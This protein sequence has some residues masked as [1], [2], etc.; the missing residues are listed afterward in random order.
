MALQH[1]FVDESRLY[2]S[3]VLSSGFTEPKMD[4]LFEFPS[5]LSIRN[6]RDVYPATDDLCFSS[7][8]ILV[9]TVLVEDRWRG[10][11]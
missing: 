10:H 9:T 5:C 1:G 3:R 6:D 4:K 2:F 8:I 7:S 11:W